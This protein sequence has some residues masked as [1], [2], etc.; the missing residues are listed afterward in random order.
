MTASDLLGLMKLVNNELETDAA[1]PDEARG[2]ASLNACQDLLDAVCAA[3]PRVLSTVGEI[4]T[5]AS[6]E[7]TTFPA[8]VMRLDGLQPLSAVAGVPTGAVIE[9]TDDV[10]GHR[11]GGPWPLLIAAGSPGRPDSFFSD[12]RRIYWGTM[13]DAVYA[14]RWYGFLKGTNFLNRN[15]TFDYPD[16]FAMPIATLATKVLKIGLDDSIDNL[17]GLAQEHF[18][19]A[20]K[21]QRSI[22]R[23]RP[24]SRMYRRP[25]DT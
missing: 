7:F 23:V 22:I 9:S 11:P 14:F 24:M 13:P 5:T 4:T 2:L 3:R 21:A 17:F 1:D 6:V 16:H 8:G 20:L 25:H 19:P 15:T 18:A 12:G 10:G